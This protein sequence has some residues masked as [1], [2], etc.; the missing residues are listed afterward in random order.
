[1][2]LNRETSKFLDIASGG[3]FLHV[4]AN[5]GRSILD[6]VLENMPL[7][8]AV[9]DKLLEAESQIAEPELCLTHHKL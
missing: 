8:K 5:L 7:P 9:E 4:S 6:K 2:G 1:M 3:S